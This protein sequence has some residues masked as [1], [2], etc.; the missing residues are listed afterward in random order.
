MDLDVPIPLFSALGENRFLKTS[1]KRD[2]IRW[3]S[4][5]RPHHLFLF[6]LLLGVLGVQADS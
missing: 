3:S 6:S 2:C 5:I 1:V 4:S